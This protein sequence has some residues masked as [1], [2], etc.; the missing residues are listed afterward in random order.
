MPGNLNAAFIPKTIPVAFY[1]LFTL[2]IALHVKC[3]RVNVR[4][5]HSRCKLCSPQQ[6]VSFNGVK[7][8]IQVAQVIKLGQG[9]I[10][11]GHTRQK[12]EEFCSTRLR[13]KTA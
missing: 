11:I 1:P 10:L 7:P 5:E 6:G 2:K 12:L 13:Q 4:G 8:L 3:R 9:S